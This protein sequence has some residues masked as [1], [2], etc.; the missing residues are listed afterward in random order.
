MKP[1]LLA[2]ALPC[3]VLAQSGP[4]PAEA[5]AQ[6]GT[7]VAVIEGET[8][9]AEDLTGAVAYR[10]Y[11]LALDRHALIRAET[12]RRVDER[13]LAAEAERRGTTPE[14]MLAAVEGEVPPVS[15]AEIDA[16][17]AEHPAEG[18]GSPEGVR[19]RVRHYLGERRRIERRL[20]FLAGL[21]EAAGYRFLLEPPVP[22]RSE[23]DV[24][25]APARGP[26][27]ADVTVLH[28]ATFSSRHSARS[29][30]K[31]AALAAEFPGRIRF[32]H[33]NLL[34]DRDERGLLAA[35]LAL[36]AREQGRFWELHDLYFAREGKLDTDVIV[37][38]A[39]E[40]GLDEDAIA[41]ARSDPA[42]LRDV[43]RDIDSANQA[44]VPR[45]PAIF[46]NGLF[47][48]GLVPAEELRRTVVQ[49]L[50]VPEG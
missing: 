44:G 6:S 17:L 3:L 18:A 1:A 27:D 7:P 37:A 24:A 16:Y 45:E 10:L 30:A 25:G 2:A 12:E 42:L 40:V 4:A 38:L 23:M 46:V 41:R 43:K 35:R 34:N 26:E 39:R 13:L 32:V 29:A 11:R 19:T 8:L 9:H 48:S 21:R 14:A 28:Y 50:G 33:R 36:V 49:E 5:E 22:P 47:V 31:L 15:E 20:A